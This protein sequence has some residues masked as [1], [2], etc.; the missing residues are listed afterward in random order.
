MTTFQRRRSAFFAGCCCAAAAVPAPSAAGPLQQATTPTP[1][2]ISAEAALER[3]ELPPVTRQ[4][5]RFEKFPII[6]WWGPPGTAS[7]RDFENYKNAGFNLYAANPDT[8]YERA[9]DLAGRVGLKVMAYRQLQGFGLPAAAAPPADYAKNRKNIVGWLTHD[10]PGGAPAVIEAITAV[11]TLLREDPT[12][13]A[14]FN[15]LPP[16]AQ[17]NPS[18][19]PVLKAAVRN[20]MPILSYDAYVIHADGTDNAGAHFRALEQFRQASLRYDAPFWAFA[21]TI[22]HFGYRRPSES[23]LRWNHYTNL[24]Y[25]AKGLWYFTYWG[26][27]DW[28]NWDTVAIV[29]PRDGAKTDLYEPV[30]KLN[31]AVG[32]M[33]DRLLRLTSLD[34]VH[35]L[36]PP[37][38]RLFVPDARWITDIK[39]TDALIGFF[40][41]RGDSGAQYALLVN[42]R[43]GMGQSPEQTADRIELTFAPSVRSVTAVNWQDGRRGRLK[44]TGGKAMLRVHGGT[45]V[46]LRLDR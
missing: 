31:Q 15:L 32:D 37:G 43:H 36:P 5:W 17:V 9:V 45:G 40:T 11:N 1:P 20:G 42:K 10:E 26:P 4:P 29:D 16:F 14:L 6:A 30:R 34:V 28:P 21:L 19:E 23:D 39:A 25:G 33:G 3:L 24:A 44:L 41:D 12:R 2:P 8:G 27:T 38:Q 7:R 18:T 13:W 35:T 46:L 22:K